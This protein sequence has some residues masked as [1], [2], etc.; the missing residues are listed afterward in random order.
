MSEWLDGVK[1]KQITVTANSTLK[2]TNT[3]GGY[4][5]IVFANSSTA[6]Y[7]GV[8]YVS[9]TVAGVTGNTPVFA[10]SGLTVTNASGGVTFTGAQNFNV[11]VLIQ[12]GDMNLVVS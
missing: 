1:F 3:G 8:Y 6:A 4:R 11:T 7:R 12:S 2:L 9:S 10:A 5:A